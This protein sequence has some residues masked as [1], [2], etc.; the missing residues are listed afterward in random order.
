VETNQDTSQ[1][2]I[3]QND[4]RFKIEGQAPIRLADNLELFDV[5]NVRFDGSNFLYE[6]H[7]HSL[8]NR[9][10]EEMSQVKEFFKKKRLMKYC[11]SR[12][13]EAYILATEHRKNT[14]KLTKEQQIQTALVRTNAKLQRYVEQN[15]EYVVTFDVDGRTFTSR[16]NKDLRVITSGI[17]LSGKDSDFDLQSLV[18]VFQEKIQ[19]DDDDGYYDTDY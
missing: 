1:G 19:N 18:T 9:L 6:S 12:F 4:N 15:G 7:N 8:D 5:V 11:P 10:L 13:Q 17:C 3:F 2:T 16:V 14:E